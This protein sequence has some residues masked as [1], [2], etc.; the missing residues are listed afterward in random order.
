MILRELPELV[1]Y[2]SQD[3]KK[4]STNSLDDMA[5]YLSLLSAW[6]VGAE[7][8]CVTLNRVEA[9]KWSTPVEEL[10]PRLDRSRVVK[11]LSQISDALRQEW[12]VA[13]PSAAQKQL[14]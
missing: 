8:T 2:S 4:L 13:E 5:M 12:V 3:S 10:G 14:E 7:Y 11:V 9:K 1:P 6:S